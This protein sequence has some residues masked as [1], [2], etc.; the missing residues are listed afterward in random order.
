[1]Q[2]AEEHPLYI[3]QHLAHELG[4]NRQYEFRL[5]WKA[6]HPLADRPVWSDIID[7]QQDDVAYAP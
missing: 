1:M 3:S 7:K 4:V 6:Q 2:L 5:E